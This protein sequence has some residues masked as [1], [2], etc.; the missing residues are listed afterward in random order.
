ML[1]DCL[2][3]GILSDVTWKFK[4]KEYRDSSFRG[5]RVATSHGSKSGVEF[6]QRWKT[7]AGKEG[8]IGKVNKIYGSDISQDCRV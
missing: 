3:R 6:Q 8:E 7:L 5:P 4:N 1:F 2:F